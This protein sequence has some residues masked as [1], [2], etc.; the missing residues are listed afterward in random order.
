[1]TI[2]D[3][4][5]HETQLRTGLVSR[6]GRLKFRTWD[7]LSALVAA[8][9]RRL[10]EQ[11]ATAAQIV[12]DFFVNSAA[13]TA[14]DRRGEGNEGSP[15]KDAVGSVGS[16][17]VTRP[18]GGGAITIPA[19]TLTFGTVPDAN[20]A[21]QTF[22]T[23]ADLTMGAGVTSA[24]VDAEST[25]LGLAANITAGTLLQI[26]SSTS[27]VTGAT[28][29]ATFTGGD[30]AESNEAYRIRL[31]LLAQSKAKANGDGLLAAVLGVS[32]AAFARVVEQATQN[33]PVLIYV[34]NSSG[35]LPG[36]LATDVSDAVDAVRAWGIPPTY[37]APS[38][39][40]VSYTLQLVWD[41]AR[42]IDMPAVTALIEADLDAYVA[43]LNLGAD[44][45]HRI[46]R[47]RDIVMG[48]KRV[49]VVDLVD[50]T[51]LPAAN[52]TLT[53]DEMAVYGGVTWL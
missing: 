25:T 40:T 35:L 43:S 12:S 24:D 17:T 45:T 19:G 15:R 26:T 2:K 27:L 7:T 11:S 1:V 42:A 23:T 34:G 38:V 48:Y 5:Y 36:D 49:G 14:L 53:D 16:M 33:P 28:A 50:D 31:R 8:L 41:T 32:G 20:G 10:G 51:L 30:E 22:V 3:A 21:R 52:Q 44:R 39:V 46:N 18:A 13:G 47:V 37:S 29:A 4:T 9:S 6:L